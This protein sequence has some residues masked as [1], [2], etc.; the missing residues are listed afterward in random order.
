Y[1][2]RKEKGLNT[3]EILE[4]VIKGI[5]PSRGMLLSK[6][7]MD[8]LEKEIAQMHSDVM[9]ENVSR[10][11]KQNI[12]DLKMLSQ[13]A[14]IARTIEN[15]WDFAALKEKAIEM[16]KKEP[17]WNGY[18]FISFTTVVGFYYRSDKDAILKDL[19]EGD[20]LSLKREPDNEYDS[21]AVAVYDTKDRQ[22]G[23]LPKESNTFMATMMDAGQDFIGR[24]F[25]FCKNGENA[26]I[27]IEIFIKN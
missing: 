14:E 17:L 25:S 11:L 13:G 16:R 2:G 8:F 15:V 5:K 21:M 7:A 24:L 22:M 27:A 19:K 4:G 10:L 1:E 20:K 12:H 3:D 6:E 9:R 23:Y 18:K 26:N